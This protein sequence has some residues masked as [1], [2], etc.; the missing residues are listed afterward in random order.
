[1]GIGGRLAS[2]DRLIWALTGARAAIDTRVGIDRVSG[3]TLADR[4][5]RADVL[6]QTASHAC[7]RNLI[8]HDILLLV[9]GRLIRSRMVPAI[10]NG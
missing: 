6:T 7:I 9:F 10:E 1:M 3:R 2:N 5:N 8:S 4:L